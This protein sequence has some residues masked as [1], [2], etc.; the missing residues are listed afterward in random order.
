MS[1]ALYF[2]RKKK[3][4]V[5]LDL[6]KRDYNLKKTFEDNREVIFN[7]DEMLV[8]IAKKY[9][10]FYIYDEYDCSLRSKIREVMCEGA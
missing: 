8:T 3:T 1:N 9:V 10:F 4:D 7:G 2:D 6:L 5:A